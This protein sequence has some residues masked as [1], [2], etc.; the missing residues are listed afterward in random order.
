MVR[1]PLTAD[2]SFAEI[3]ARN[4]LGIAMAA[5]I[6]MIATTINSSMSENPPCLRISGSVTIYVLLHI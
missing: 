1:M 4:R 2:A 5:M 6:R 3:R